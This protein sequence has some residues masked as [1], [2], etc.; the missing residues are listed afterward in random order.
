MNSVNEQN[1][2]QKEKILAQSRKASKDEGMENAVIKGLKISTIIAW[3][4]GAYFFVLFRI[5]GNRDA[6]MGII[7]ISFSFDIGKTFSLY[8]FTRKKRYLAW[9][10]FITLLASSIFVL[11]SIELIHGHFWGS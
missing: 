8:R 2:A 9:L 11:M 5:V 7:L 1:I 4:V 3:L 10:I 6:A